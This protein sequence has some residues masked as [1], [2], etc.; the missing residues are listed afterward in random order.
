MFGVVPEAAGTSETGSFLYHPNLVCQGASAAGS[1]LG[2]F[3]SH[4]GVWVMP[5]SQAKN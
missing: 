3:L 1:R 2:H 5:G 4:R